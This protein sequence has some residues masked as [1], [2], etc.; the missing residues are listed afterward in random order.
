M[1]RLFFT[2]FIALAALAIVSCGSVAEPDRNIVINEL[3]A[4]NRTGLLKNGKKPADWIELKN[5]SDHPV[6]LEG[7]ELSV[8]KTLPDSMSAANGATPEKWELPD[9]NIGPGECLVIFCDKKKKKEVD[10]KKEKKEKK[11]KAAD[12][13]EKA[14]KDLSADFNLPK[15]GATVRLVA[16]G[17]KT[18]SEVK[19]GALEPDQALALQA[20]KTYK[21]TFWQSPGFDN[22]R[23]GYEEAMLKIDGQRQSPLKIWELMSRA[24]H[25]YDNWVELKNVSD[26]PLDLSAYRISKKMDK[27]EGW[28]LPARTL[29]PGE[30]IS[31]QLA[32]GK[33]A[34]NNPQQAPFKIGS[35]ETVVLIKDSTFADGM[36]ARLTPYGGS[37]GRQIGQQGFFFF[38]TPSRNA[39]N[40]SAGLRYIAENPAFDQKPGIY[41]DKEKMVIRLRD[42]TRPVHYTLDGS[43]PTMSSPVLKDSLVLTKPTV[44]RSFAEGDSVTMRSN[45]A[46]TSYLLGVDHDLPVIN[47]SVNNGDLY[48]HSNG[49]YA[50][51]PGY[52]GDF[53]YMGANFWKNW[54]KKAHVEMFDD[55][56]GFASDCGLKIFGG[57]SRALAKKSL[58]LKFRGQFGDAKVNYD[59]FGTGQPMDFEDLVLRSGSQDYN[60]YMLK[61]EFFTSLAQKGSDTGSMLTQMYRPVAVYINAEYFGLF[62][63][64]EKVD[65]NFVARKLNLPNDSIDIHLS[66]PSEYRKMVT[67]IQGM[68]MSKPENY[69][70]ARQNIDLVSLIDYKIGSIYAGRG[71]VGNIRHVRSRAAGSDRKWRFVFYDIDVSWQ[72]SGKPS[73]RFFLSTASDAIVPE[74]AFHNVLM[75]KL[76]R[77]K[78]FRQLFL[79]RLSY[80]LAN[81]YSAKTA[82]EH[83]DKFV[84]QIRNEMKH[85]CKRWPGLSYEKWE[86]NIAEFR[87]RFDNRPQLVLNDLRKY[88]SIT[89]EE[90]KKYFSSLGY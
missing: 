22:N 34:K 21:P 8:E 40:G 57:F 48:N 7:Y 28:Q 81:T 87:S 68:D 14:A 5:T 76:L 26:Q 86:K 19:Y 1:N 83:F 73:A 15:E 61:D 6:N 69:E 36:C 11:K 85:N 17:N 39:D 58:R 66:G 56:G 32:G 80:H 42:K 71:D 64:R 44:I 24:G 41:K 54:T 62:Y 72:A 60:R 70:F 47:I 53:P 65:K 52:G 88:L 12:D 31:F 29:A 78:D 90:N 45:I 38:D 35:N 67:R 20:D 43:E 50:D 2:S 89:D 59:F 10:A 49:I 25:S 37:I 13:K 3:M 9:V 33:A 4:S 46:T 55:K 30:I 74:K 75:E 27:S 63:L 84:A 16:H 82:T 79:E 77:N 51:G 23:K 18:I